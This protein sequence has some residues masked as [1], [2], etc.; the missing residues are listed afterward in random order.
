MMKK[1]NFAM[2]D[3]RLIHGQVIRRWLQHLKIDRIIV[4]DDEVAVDII[5]KK[6]ITLAAPEGLALN[7]VS[8]LEFLEL[9]E[10][11]EMKALVLVRTLETLSKLLDQGVTLI[12]LSISRIP[13]DVG[14]KKFEKAVYLN[15]DEVILLRGLIRKQI[16][17]YAQTVPEDEKIDIKQRID[18]YEKMFQ[19]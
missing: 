3:N 19:E 18:F 4:I 8:C 5:E 17:V 16:N 2:C 13:T 7:I 1:I 12:T 6:L 9:D 11:K 14:R 15:R 10:E